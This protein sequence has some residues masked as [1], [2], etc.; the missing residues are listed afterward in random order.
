[1]I[2]TLTGENSFAVA[3]AE[4][5]IVDAF[6]AKHGAN[7]VERVDVEGLVPNRLPDLLQGVTLFAPARLVIFKN[8]SANKPVLEPLADALKKAAADTTVVIA[9]SALDKRT[10]LYKFL[11]TD[12]TFKEFI[13]LSDGQIVRWLEAEATRLGS[14]LTPADAQ[15]LVARAGRDQ[16]RLASEIQKLANAPVITTMIIEQLV[17][18]TPEGTA[19]ELLDAALAGD[20][21]A[22][23]RHLHALKMQEDPYKLFGL[24]ASQ[25][26]TLAVVATAGARHPDIIAQE[27]GLHPFVVRKT[28]AIAKRLGP[29]HIKQLVAHVATCDVQLKSSGADPWDVLHICLY[30]IAS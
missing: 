12:S 1:M 22:L 18:P 23:A 27:A 11:K 25:I 13:N 2:M 20:K 5:Q 14:S 4:R 28:Q 8:L 19:F 6:T 9:D 7:G 26:H 17:E 29:A 15:L 3:A 24:L 10:K 30:K 21:A 16:W